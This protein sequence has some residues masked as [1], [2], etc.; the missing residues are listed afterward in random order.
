LIPQVFERRRQSSSEDPE[1]TIRLIT[2][3][4]QDPGHLEPA[5]ETAAVVAASH[6]ARCEC[7]ACRVHPK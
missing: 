7:L 6:E 2:S 1:F 3:W 5:T 4:T